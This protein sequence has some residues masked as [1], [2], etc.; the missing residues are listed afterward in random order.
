[1]NWFQLMSINNKLIFFFMSCNGVL[2]SFL[3]DKVW[4]WIWHGAVFIGLGYLSFPSIDI[5]TN[6]TE[7]KKSKSRTARSKHFSNVK[8]IQVCTLHIA[9]II[10]IHI[11]ISCTLLRTSIVNFGVFSFFFPSF[12]VCVVVCGT[13]CCWWWWCFGLFN[14]FKFQWDIHNATAGRVAGEQHV[15][16]QWLFGKR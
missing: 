6:Q 4:G 5:W 13:C 9:H 1:M 11:Y 16:W 12:G 8:C 15:I 2:F 14:C 3:A 7:C 10:H